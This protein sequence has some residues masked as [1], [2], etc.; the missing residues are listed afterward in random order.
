MQ[1]TDILHFWFDEL[2]NQRRFAKDAALDA[3]IRERFGLTLQAAIRGELAHWRAT[4]Q[5]RLAEI[6]VLDQFSRN[7][8]RDQP[9]SFAQDPQALT[10]AQELVGTGQ[11]ITLASE[12]RAF[13]YMPYMHSESALVHAQAVVLFSE[14]G[15]EANLNYE[16][17]HQAIIGRFGRFPHRNAVLG[18]VSTPEEKAFLQQ[19]GSSF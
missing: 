13:A 19:P 1:T 11:A 15:L 8:F 17:K 16:L 3:L 4:P 18:R 2:D 14:P 7:L 6:I 9:A 5:G 12:Q 10:L